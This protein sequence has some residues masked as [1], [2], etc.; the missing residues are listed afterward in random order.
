MDISNRE[1]KYYGDIELRTGTSQSSF[2][3]LLF[4]DILVFL[5]KVSS[6]ENEKRYALKPLSFSLEK[7]HCTFTPIVPMHCIISLHQ[8]ENEKRG[9]YIV[10]IIPESTHSQSFKQKTSMTSQMLFM[11]TTKS[12]DDRTK[13]LSHLQSSI[14][15]GKFEY[16][17]KDSR[18]NAE[19]DHLS[20]KTN[21]F[22]NNFNTENLDSKS[23][24]F[25]P[26]FSY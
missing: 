3:A 16:H 8:I 5:E 20:T 11:L 17:R 2:L 13:W 14:G 23:M 19:C 26:N 1:L 10:V 7:K 6:N 4:T 9:F 18:T 25:F 15:V 12:G 24:M 22:L 21:N